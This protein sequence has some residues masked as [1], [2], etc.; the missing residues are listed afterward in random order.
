M[1]EEYQMQESWHNDEDSKLVQQLPFQFCKSCKMPL[2]H[3]ILFFCHA[4]C[5]FILLDPDL[6]ESP[7]TARRN[8]G[9]YLRPFK[10]IST[11]DRKPENGSVSLFLLLNALSLA[12]MAGDV[13]LFLNDHDNRHAAEIEV[14]GCIHV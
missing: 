5:T 8:A 10:A 6:P 12:G 14:N 9:S 2:Q 4:E 13:N 11:M 3:L 7:A 1:Q